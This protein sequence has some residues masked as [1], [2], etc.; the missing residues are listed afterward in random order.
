[1]TSKLPRMTS[2]C[3]MWE[4][5]VVSWYI[6]WHVRLNV[7][8]INCAASQ[9]NW[10]TSLVRLRGGGL[11]GWGFENLTLNENRHQHIIARNHFGCVCALALSYLRTIMRCWC[12]G[13]LGF[14]N[15][16]VE[17]QML[18]VGRKVKPQ[19]PD[20]ER[21]TWLQLSEGFPTTHVCMHS[22]ENR[23]SQMSTPTHYTQNPTAGCICF[24][25]AGSIYIVYRLFVCDQ[26]ASST[27]SKALSPKSQPVMVWLSSQ[28]TAWGYEVA[29]PPSVI[30]PNSG[31]MSA[32]NP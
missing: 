23:N 18:Y 9:A 4:E 5:M 26:C 17:H 3:C 29:W 25:P 10:R 16:W 19:G 1:M 11:R 7:F 30:Q 8:G 14:T 28:G 31:D 15:S 12:A 21:K 13:L 6:S 32:L 20:W 24:G 2:T 27:P 22:T